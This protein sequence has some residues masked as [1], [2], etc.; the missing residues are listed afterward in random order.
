[1]TFLG[2]SVAH[3]VKL[4]RVKSAHCE[5]HGNYEARPYFGSR[6]SGCPACAN[7]YEAKLSLQ[8]SAEKEERLARIFQGKLERSSIPP[9]FQNC[10]L[11]NYVYSEVSDV[12][13]KQISM[14]KEAANFINNFDANLKLSKCMFFLGNVGTG[15]THIACAMAIELI[16]SGYTVKYTTIDDYFVTVRDTYKASSNSS[17]L[18]VRDEYAAYDFLI[19]DEL[20]IQSCSESEDRLMLSLLDKR[21]RD[22]KTTLFISN[23]DKS[24]LDVILGARLISRIR[25]GGALMKYFTWEDFR[26]LK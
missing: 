5:L 2:E 21:Y 19:I 14:L 11:T 22:L 17:E 18:L 4:V 13:G 7:E 10:S 20:G 24:E 1:M 16:K 25:Q 9:I 12:R 26:V 8:A 23:K 15:K 6:W 3:D